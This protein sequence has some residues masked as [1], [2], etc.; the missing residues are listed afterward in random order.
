MILVRLLRTCGCVR[1]IS[2]EYGFSPETSNL[3]KTIQLATDKVL[4][5]V[6]PVADIL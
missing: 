5:Q 1:W 3:L 4:Q 2:V 6:Y